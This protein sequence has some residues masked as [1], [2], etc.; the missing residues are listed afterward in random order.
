LNADHSFFVIHLSETRRGVG[1][2]LPPSLDAGSGSVSFC[3]QL[4]HAP[5]PAV[6]SRSVSGMPSPRL[7]FL[8]RQI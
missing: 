1:A 2:F 4:R 5:L 6:F 7:P 8:W 3:S